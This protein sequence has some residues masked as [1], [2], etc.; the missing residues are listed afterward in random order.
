MKSF[1]FISILLFLIIF[2]IIPVLDPFTNIFAR[3]IFG[4]TGIVPALVFSSSSHY[5]KKYL[6]NNEQKKA[7]WKPFVISFSG[8][9][10][11]LIVGSVIIN[12]N[13]AGHGCGELGVQLR[14]IVAAILLSLSLAGIFSF[15]PSLIL[16][17]KY[18]RTSHV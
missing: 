18:K 16:W 17:N 4:I 6:Q 5:A 10:I 12:V 11:V 13:C 1:L 14:F 7:L 2:F 8:L 9:A 15:V 3:I